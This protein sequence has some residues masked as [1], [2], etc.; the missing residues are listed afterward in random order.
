MYIYLYRL[1][2]M[3][4]NIFSYNEPLLGHFCRKLYIQVTS[5]IRTLLISQIPCK[6]WTRFF[7]GE[8]RYP[9]KIDLENISVSNRHFGKPDLQHLRKVLI[10]ALCVHRLHF[11]HLKGHQHGQPEMRYEMVEVLSWENGGGFYGKIIPI[12]YT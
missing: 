3:Y 6:K 12:I 10:N 5:F 7:A 9:C 4:H 2:Y 1:L 8:R 11:F